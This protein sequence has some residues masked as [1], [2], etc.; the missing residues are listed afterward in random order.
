MRGFSTILVERADLA[1]G[2]SGRFHGLLHSGA[3]Y[4][5]S[6]PESATECCV[7]NRILKRIQPDAI[8]PTGG[9]FVALEGD[10][11]DYSD[12]F[13]RAMERNGLPHEEVRLAL[14]RRLEPRLTRRAVQVISVDDAAVDGWALALGTVRSALEYGARVL[15]YTEVKGIGLT[16]GRTSTVHCRDRRSGE[17]FVIE[18]GF[19]I[20]AAG[21][22]VGRVATLLGIE[23][24]T[25]EPAQ[26]I[27][28]AVSQRLVS[29]VLNRLRYPG[30]GDI[31]VPAQTVS[32]IGTTDAPASD[33][34][35]LVMPRDKIQQMLDCGEA[36]VPGFRQARGLHCWVGA[37]PLI[38]DDSVKPAETRKMRRGMFIFDHAS[39]DGVEGMLSVAGGKLTT[40]RLMAQEVVDQMCL[41]LGSPRR[42]RTASEPV[43]PP[44]T[45]HF[46]AGQVTKPGAG[47]EAPEIEQP[48]W[49]ISPAGRQR[50]TGPRHITDRLAEAESTRADDQIICECELVSRRA[51]VSALRRHPDDSLDDLRRRL[52]IGM[53]PCQGGFCAARSAGI[54]CQED[55]W[56][57]G[58]AVAALRLFLRNRWIG[59]QPLVYG[60][61][62]KQIA[63]DNW[64]LYGTLGLEQ[65]PASQEVVL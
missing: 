51:L 41:K 17:D 13:L 54:A 27:M 44:P 4:A 30:D 7:E 52:R 55:A 15:R 22:W 42:C 5:V 2:T 34:D 3:R 49:P 47:A 58:Q 65:L 48:D 32:I 9:W 28:V 31:M 23:D 61:L 11:P 62:L 50:P 21:P 6:D 59:Q 57:A 37:R 53:G 43:P 1:Q 40:Y 60:E 36:L 14:A 16:G 64:M 39:R 35:R 56:S 19:I 8:E 29:R 12:K 25:V 33:P 24:V 18:A 63:L 10:G 26:G 45:D 38:R 46:V 20:N